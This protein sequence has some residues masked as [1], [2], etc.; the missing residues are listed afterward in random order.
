MTYSETLDYLFSQLPMF[1]RIGSAAYKGDLNNTLAL[2]AHMGHPHRA[3]KVVHV[4]GT[5]GKGSVSHALA[6]VL[7]QAGYR[8][9]LYTSPHLIDFRERIRIN[10]AVISESEVVDFVNRYKGLLDEVK[11]SFFEMTVAMAF[12]YFRRMEVDVAVVEVGMGG[13][14]DSTNI[15]WPVLS[16][17]TNIGLD[18][19]A[20]LGTTLAQ[21]AAEKAGIVKPGIPVAIGAHHAETDT[22]FEQE[23]L[24]NHSA[25]VYAQDRYVLGLA[26]LSLN[27]NSLF[28]IQSV[29]GKNWSNLELDLNGFYQQK[30]ILTILTAI[31]LLVQRGFRISESDT[32]KGLAGVSGLTGLRG[33][34]QV[35]G[36]NPRMVVDTGHNAHG[37]AE[38]VRQIE[39]TPH[40][41][42]HLVWG[43]VNDKDTKEVL[44]LLPQDA[45]CY[46]TRA[47]IPR[48]LP[49]ETLRATAMQ[50]GLK[51]DAF[52][53][54]PAAIQQAKKNAGVN[55][56]I[57]I[58]GSTFVVAD[59]LSFF[60]KH[61]ELTT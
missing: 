7:Q 53:D 10:G 29:T 47:S 55:D 51:G 42:L 23:A 16:V 26:T 15:V 4:A 6:A 31:D 21:I 14:L 20:F 44:E 33:R 45:T 35:V 19:T 49:S 39:A 38:V 36:A 24:L 56:L 46:F 59:A 11:P 40:E 8:T 1:Q 50:I 61:L 3:F 25:L 9:G 5:N 34:W 57:F 28:Q 32:R 48:S 52:P 17:I 30:N 54:V 58:G 2:D 37:I 22:V 43:M 41:R 13:R 27:G 60:D 12:E 18:H